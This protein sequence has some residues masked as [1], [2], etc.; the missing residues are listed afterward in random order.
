MLNKAAILLAGVLIAVAAQD[1]NANGK[2]AKRAPAPAPVIVEAPPPYVAYNWT[3]LYAGGNLGVAF[4][5]VDHYYERNN[6][7]DD[8][9]QVWLD[10]SG[11]SFSGHVGYQHQFPNLFVIGVEAEIGKLGIDEERLV[12][13]DDD[14]LRS[15]TDFFGTIRGRLGYAMGRFL[16]YVTGG[17]AWVDVENAGGNPANDQRFLTIS[18]TRPGYV[19]GAGAE[20]AFTNNMIARLEYLYIDVD[21]FEVRNLENEKMRF[22]NNFHLVRAGLSY[23]F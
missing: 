4:T 1:A 2:P 21:E 12:I 7:Q 19:L 5:N 3:G 9:G 11:Y 20:Y 14:V 18:E 13:K 15:K 22:D 16:P 17:F 10:A 23:R 8:H 6:G